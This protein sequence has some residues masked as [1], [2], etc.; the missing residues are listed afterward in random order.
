[1]HIAPGSI[2]CGS[3]QIGEGSLIGAGSTIIPGVRIGK[4]TVI[5]AGSVVTKDIPDHVTAVGSPCKIIK[6]H[7]GE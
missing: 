6:Q 2:L 5:G 1:V 7:N 4:W 3:V